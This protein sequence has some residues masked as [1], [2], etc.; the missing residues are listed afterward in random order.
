MFNPNGSFLLPMQ[1][2]VVTCAFYNLRVGNFFIIFFIIIIH[3]YYY[4]DIIKEYC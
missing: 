2:D 4:Y 3:Y 1:N